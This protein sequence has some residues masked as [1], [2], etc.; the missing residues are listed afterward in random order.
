MECEGGDVRERE[1][2]VRGRCEGEA[3]ERSVCVCVCVPCVGDSERGGGGGGGEKRMEGERERETRYSVMCGVKLV[4]QCQPQGCL[5][6]LPRVATPPGPTGLSWVYVCVLGERIIHAML[7]VESICACMCVCGGVQV[8]L[9]KENIFQFFC[10][11]LWTTS[12]PSLPSFPFP[13][14][15]FP[16]PLPSLLSSPPVTNVSLLE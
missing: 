8:L 13:P 12:H 14:H 1:W 9:M 16:P 11:H 7:V 2:S 15:H 5:P 10:C 4:C 3:V 6:I